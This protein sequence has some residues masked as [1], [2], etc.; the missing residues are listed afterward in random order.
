MEDKWKNHLF[1]II[2]T[3]IVYVV[4]DLVGLFIWFFA[5]TLMYLFQDRLI[6][7]VSKELYK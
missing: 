4:F 5:I 3:I 7:I 6:Y 2:A 1:S